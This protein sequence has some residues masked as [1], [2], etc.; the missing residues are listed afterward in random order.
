MRE[1]R[2]D[3]R[4]SEVVQILGFKVMETSHLQNGQVL[5]NHHDIRNK[6]GEIVS[7]NYENCDE[8]I[9]LLRN[10]ANYLK[11]NARQK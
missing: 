8:P 6:D 9:R 3:Y 10:L 5:K 11:A 1:Y 7:R 2:T 4:T